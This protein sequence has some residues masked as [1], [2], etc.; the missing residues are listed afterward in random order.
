MFYGPTAVRRS[1]C[2]TSCSGGFILLNKKAGITS[3]EALSPVKKALGTGKVGHTGSLDR[4]ADG[5]LVIL[6]GKALKLTPY[7]TG[8]DKRY[9]ALVR[10]GIETCTLDPEG[11]VVAEAPVPP[12]AVLKTAL[13]QFRGEITQIP[14]VFSAIHVNGKRAY[15]LARDGVPVSMKSRRITVHELTLRSYDPPLARISVHCSAGTYIRA[16]ARDIAIAAG[17]RA[18]LA[19][20]KR[21]MTGTFRLPDA[22]NPPDPPDLESIR[23]SVR[24]IDEALF[25]ALSIPVARVDEKTAANMRQGRPID[26]GDV[27]CEYPV[28]KA[29]VFCDGSFIALIEKPPQDSP[30][31]WRYAF[32]F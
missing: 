5:L 14:P 9:E 21:T 18:H 6:A 23:L 3:F 26:P 31:T 2:K 15:Q 7:I 1:I 19:A 28:S 24:P 27:P 32:V 25:D 16:L 12:E 29:A 22:L 4:F 8:C 13:E 10:M 30:G 11:A 20:L 17:S